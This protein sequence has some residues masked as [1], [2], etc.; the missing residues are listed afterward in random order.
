MAREHTPKMLRGLVAL[1]L[2]SRHAQSYVGPVALPRGRTSLSAAGGA[3]AGGAAAAL[4][5]GGMPSLSDDELARL[6][7]EGRVERRSV[8]G[9]AGEA[10]VVVDS[11]LAPE[12]VLA[13]RGRAGDVG[14]AV[15]STSVSGRARTARARSSRARASR[16]SV[17]RPRRSSGTFRGGRRSCGGSGPRAS[18]ASTAGASARPSRSRSSGCPRTSSS[19]P[20]APSSPSASTPPRRTSPSSASPAR[21]ASSPATAAGAASR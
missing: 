16:R 14:R 13:A 9:R 8:A 17:R 7:A 18:A 3:G 15:A 10:A 11:A 2:A 12:A 21:G 1:V 6:A 19:R 5:R 4:P 20:A